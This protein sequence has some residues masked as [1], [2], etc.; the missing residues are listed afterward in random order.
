MTVEAPQSLEDLQ[1]DEPTSISDSTVSSA[2][3]VDGMKFLA[4][5]YPSIYTA[6][7][8]RPK[9]TL[10]PKTVALGRATALA[11]YNEE[12]QRSYARAKT[13]LEGLHMSMEDFDF[14]SELNEGFEGGTEASDDERIDTPSS[15]LSLVS[16]LSSNDSIENSSNQVWS[17]QE[18][19]RVF[20]TCEDGR[21]CVVSNTECSYD[22]EEP[23]ERDSASESMSSPTEY[24]PLL[25][26]GIN[27]PSALF[28]EGSSGS[29]EQ[30]ASQGE[31]AAVQAPFAIDNSRLPAPTIDEIARDFLGASQDWLTLNVPSTPGSVSCSEK[32]TAITGYQDSLTLTPSFIEW[33]SEMSN[34]SS[35]IDQSPSFGR[36]PAGMPN[37]S[38]APDPTSSE[39]MSSSSS[40]ADD[41]STLK[42][43][44]PVPAVFPDWTVELIRVRLG[45]ESL[46]TS[47][48]LL[49]ADE[50][51]ATTKVALI[52]AFLTLIAAEREKLDLPALPS[53]CTATSV[54]TSKIMPHITV[55]GTTSLATFLAQSDFNEDDRVEAEEI[56]RVFKILCKE[57]TRKNLLATAIIMGKIGRRLG[58]LLFM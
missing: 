45:I 28:L 3:Q 22:V 52:T 51:G 23:N 49:D 43:Q 47:L 36:N 56:Y 44:S 29:G 31:G 48:S 54:L 34:Y 58:K 40:S 15:E 5:T 33:P 12:A 38:P 14:D 17:Q 32:L 30:I 7:L 39:S 46:F 42:D 21:C 16:L 6:A 25:L 55:L 20:V 13:N 4:M 57:E 26:E 18:H 10:T 11:A 35:N 27:G 50:E 41:A 24:Q 2:A 53:T 37:Q 8:G 9:D 19:R 1:S